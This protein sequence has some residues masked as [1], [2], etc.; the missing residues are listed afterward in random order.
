MKIEIMN[1]TN[2]KENHQIYLISTFLS[3]YNPKIDFV[4]A[5]LS[6]TELIVCQNIICYW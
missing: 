2:S 6:I 1:I 5:I 3:I 4:S